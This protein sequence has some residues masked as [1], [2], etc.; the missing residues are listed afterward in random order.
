[1]SLK[2]YRNFTHFKLTFP[3]SLRPRFETSEG[4]QEI[5]IPPVL[6]LLGAIWIFSLK[7]Y[8]AQANNL[9]MK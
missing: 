6:F 8:I 1:M 4:F 7:K 5:S 3:K 2:I 9:G